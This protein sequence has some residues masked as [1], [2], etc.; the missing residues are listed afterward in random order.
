FDFLKAVSKIVWLGFLFLVFSGLGLLIFY[1]LNFGASEIVFRPGFLAKMTVALVIFF[2]GLL[3][4]WKVFP[5]FEANLGKTLNQSPDFLKNSRWVFYTGVIS[6]ISWYSA[7][8]LGAWQGLEFSYSKI[9][10][11]YIFSL[12]AGIAAA[13]LIGKKILKK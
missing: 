6:I 12:F 7:L 10:L 13:N 1:R 9:L 2:N 3:M 5:L 11:I 8:V 4:H